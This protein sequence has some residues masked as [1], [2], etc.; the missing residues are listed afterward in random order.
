MA[1]KKK[2]LGR[3]LK[4]PYN[5]PQYESVPN[6]AKKETVYFEADD[7]A[8]FYHLLGQVNDIGQLSTLLNR[9]EQALAAAEGN[10][11]LPAKVKHPNWEGSLVREY[12]KCNK[13]DCT[14]CSDG[15][16]G[17]GPYY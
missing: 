10:A 7:L 5:K 16:Q 12:T 17:H 3:K 9:V 13:K 2:Y 11:K 15:G 4:P 8:A 14:T 1:R 6:P